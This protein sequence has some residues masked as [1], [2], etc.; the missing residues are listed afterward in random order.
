[1]KAG[2]ASAILVA[3]VV[4]GAGAV[5]VHVK[6]H[7][8][9]SPWLMCRPYQHV[10]TASSAGVRYVVRNDNYG[11]E[12]ECILD[13]AGRPGFVVVSSA[14]RAS[15]AEPVAYP[16][17]FVGCSWGVCSPRS[18]L[19]MRVGRV[20]SLVTSWSTRLRA[21]G[22]WSAGYDIWFDRTRSVSGQSRGAEL[23]IW[24]NA[25]GLGPNQWP[26][27]DVDHQSWHLAH[28]ITSHQGRRWTYLQFRLARSAA[29]VRDLEVR[30][31]IMAAEHAGL[32]RPGWWLVAVEAGFE[33]WRGGA[34]LRTTGFSV[35]V[36][37]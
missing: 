9:P 24:L 14:A 10:T 3:V 4:A 29:S 30:P 33:I 32:I 28:W 8:D 17:I 25:R 27:L 22:Q 37:P 5:A 6:A 19:P 2:T 31:F 23:M 36:R 21:G 26:V 16:D 1:M 15:H 18:G 13:R 35:R 34:G 7:P 11:H 20:R 12:R